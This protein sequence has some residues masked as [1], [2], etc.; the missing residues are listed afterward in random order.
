MRGRAWTTSNPKEKKVPST[1]TIRASLSPA[2]GRRW[3][4]W[5]GRQRPRTLSF[6]LAGV[7][8]RWCGRSSPNWQFQERRQ[9]P[10]R[11]VPG[12]S[13]PCCPQSFPI[14][15]GLC[16]EEGATKTMLRRAPRCWKWSHHSRSDEPL[17]APRTRGGKANAGP[18]DHF[19][20]SQA[21][22]PAGMAYQ[23]HP[24]VGQMGEFPCLGVR[25]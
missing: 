14:A 25:R 18:R 13:P 8:S 5:R 12:K 10:G 16:C 9:P 19:A 6:T 7:L 3:K 4:I 22:R 11:A 17:V 15:N 21:L 23:G 2:S 20:R 1:P 24:A